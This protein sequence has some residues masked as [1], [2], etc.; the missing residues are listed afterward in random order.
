MT[1]NIK[2]TRWTSCEVKRRPTVLWAVQNRGEPAPSMCQMQ[3]ELKWLQ[4]NVKKTSPW[5]SKSLVCFSKTQIRFLYT[6]VGSPPKTV[7]H[8]AF[9][10]QTFGIVFSPDVPRRRLHWTWPSAHPGALWVEDATKSKVE[11]ISTAWASKYGP[12]YSSTVKVGCS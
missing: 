12:K 1:K 7:G 5:A 2:N 3:K 9:L 4:K 11:N 6:E 8:H 10:H